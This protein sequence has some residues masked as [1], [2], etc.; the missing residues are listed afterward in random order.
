MKTI[1]II[2][3]LHKGIQLNELAP[4]PSDYKAPVKEEQD[5][6]NDERHGE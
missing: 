5:N 6:G 1:N 3:D 2:E 4:K